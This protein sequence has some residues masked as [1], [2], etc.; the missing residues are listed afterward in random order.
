[1]VSRTV[2]LVDSLPVSGR[3][4]QDRG[5]D[6]HE[7]TDREVHVSGGLERGTGPDG[8]DQDKDCVRRRQADE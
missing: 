7:A 5:V 3:V 8:G 2:A 1:M 6:G 4:R